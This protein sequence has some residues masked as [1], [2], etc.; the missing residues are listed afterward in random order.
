MDG[1]LWAGPELNPNDPNPMN[2]NGKCLKQFLDE[3]ENLVLVNSQHFCHGLITRLRKTVIRTEKAVLDFF[4]VCNKILPFIIKMLIDEDRKF[5]L[6]NFNGKVKDSDHF[7]LILEV[8]LSLQ[9][10][11]KQRMEMF[12]F[13]NH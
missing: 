13:K 11:K 9:R 6:T 1:N 8:N 2:K 4:I 3:N 10:T 12:N 7:T 5:S